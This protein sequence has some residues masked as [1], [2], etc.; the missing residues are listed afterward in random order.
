[1][2]G[3]SALPTGHAA[4]CVFL[5]TSAPRRTLGLPRLPTARDS[6]SRRLGRLCWDAQ[7]L[8]C[9]SIDTRGSRDT[10]R[11]GYDGGI[12]VIQT[13]ARSQHQ[14]PLTTAFPA[15]VRPVG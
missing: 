6:E 13:R 5:P 2:A 15:I 11:Y 8:D 1:M 3:G 12:A 10:P 4:P 7:G 14:A 9:E